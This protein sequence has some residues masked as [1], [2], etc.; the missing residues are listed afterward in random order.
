MAAIR[1]FSSSLV[2]GRLWLWKVALLGVCDRDLG[3]PDFRGLDGPGTGG[4]SGGISE[5]V[6][7]DECCW[8][9]CCGSKFEFS[10]DGT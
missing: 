6:K 1:Q 5:A 7:S 2:Q 10:K 8:V 3:V 4:T 9:Y